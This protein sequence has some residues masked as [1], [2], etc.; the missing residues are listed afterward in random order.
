LSIRANNSKSADDPSLPAGYNQKADPA[1]TD[2]PYPLLGRGVY[3]ARCLG[4]NHEVI[5]FAVN[6]DHCLIPKDQGGVQYIPPGDNPMT[7]NAELW[8][9][10]DRLDPI[11]R[12]K[13]SA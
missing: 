4:P 7:A 10:L 2:Y 8:E 11:Q 1:L 12:L 5:L 3:R 13:V 6:H 9:V